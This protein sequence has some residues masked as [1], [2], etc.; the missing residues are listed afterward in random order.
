MSPK[1]F[2]LIDYQNVA[3]F[4]LYQLKKLNPKNAPLGYIIERYNLPANQYS[5]EHQQFNKNKNKN[6]KGEP[7][8][9]ADFINY[10]VK[11]QHFDLNQPI[12][13]KPNEHVFKFEFTT[14]APLIVGMSDPHVSGSNLHYCSLTGLP[15]LRGS[16]L[17]GMFRH[18]LLTLREQNEADKK[19]CRLVDDWLSDWLGEGTDDGTETKQGAFKFLDSYPVRRKTQEVDKAQESKKGE[20][21]EKDVEKEVEKE[22]KDTKTKLLR[23]VTFTNL[24]GKTAL[25]L[26][27]LA[28]DKGIVFKVNVAPLKGID[29]TDDIKRDSAERFIFHFQNMFKFM[30]LGAKTSAGLGEILC[31]DD[32]G[33]CDKFKSDNT[34]DNR[35]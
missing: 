35:D 19:V 18:Y 28:I 9:R 2:T 14:Q 1:Q 13:Y 8:L 16:S 27:Y 23:A 21:A 33:L 7:C 30:H 31:I 24:Q 10:F 5:R 6:K 22:N 34:I 17:K 12:A 32:G 3:A 25:P 11:K 26:P 29:S 4:Y 20:D 15:V